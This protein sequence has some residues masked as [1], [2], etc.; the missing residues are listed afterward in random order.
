M[1]FLLLFIFTTSLSTKIF[2]QE[3]VVSAEKMNVFY[4]GVDNP[5]SIATSN[6]SCN[7]QIINING[8]EITGLNC[9]Y[10]VRCNKIGT[11]AITVTTTKKL[12]RGI[13]T[14]YEFRVK[15][16]PKPTFKIAQ[17]GSLNLSASKEALQNQEYVRASLDNIDFFV[18]YSVDSFR[19]KIVRDSIE[20][21]SFNNKGNKISNE[22]HTALMKIEK[23][24]VIIFDRIFANSYHISSSLNDYYNSN[25]Y[26]E[27]GYPIKK[28]IVNSKMDK[29]L[30]L[31]LE[32]LKLVIQ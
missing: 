1:K 5:V 8:G 20:T 22:V 9:K 32:P 21:F 28:E 24:D 23:G 11:C 3:T 27:K 10:L 19:I 31:Q 6:T 30:K 18:D 2:S 29:Y 13:Q 17:Y 7:E 14:L 25:L 15:M 12:K 26:D 4:V 16:L